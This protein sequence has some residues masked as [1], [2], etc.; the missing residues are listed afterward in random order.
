MILPTTQVILLPQLVQ[1]A[2][3]SIGAEMALCR[4]AEMLVQPG[5]TTA[6]MSAFQ[7]YDSSG[8]GYLDVGE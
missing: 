4:L 8:D 6:A 3:D 1:M 7:Q 5:N 2:E